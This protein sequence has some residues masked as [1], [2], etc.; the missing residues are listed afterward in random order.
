[1]SF[2]ERVTSVLADCGV[3]H[4]LLG[5]SAHEVDVVVPRSSLSALDA[6]LRLGRL[7]RVVQHSHHEAPWSRWYA[8]ETSEPGRYRWL[9]VACDPFGIGPYGLGPA[10]ALRHPGSAGRTCYRAAKL[11]V[12]GGE[13]AALRAEYDADPAAAAEALER[14]F[15]SAGRKLA[16]ALATDDGLPEALAQLGG[17]IQ[18]RRLTLERLVLRA[19]FGGI[20]AVRRLLRPS[21]LAIV[22]CGPDGVGKSTVTQGLLALR[23]SPFRRIVRLGQRRGPL[24]PPSRL[25]GRRPGDAT[26]PHARVP[27]GLLG[28][29]ARLAYMWLDAILG[30]VPRVALP[31]RRT[32]LVVLERGYDDTTVDPRRYRLSTPDWVAGA[33]AAL[34]PRPDLVVVLDAPADAICAR[35][36]ELARDEIDRQLEIWRGRGHV[37]VDASGS[38]EETLNA[39]LRAI[40]DRLAARHR[41]LHSADTAVRA[42]GTPAPGGVPYGVTSR[43][44]RTRF[45]VPPGRGPLHARVY[46]PG[47]TRDAI[48]ARALELRARTRLQRSLRLDPSGGIA[49][50]VADA[51]GVRN[52]QLAA[53][54]QRDDARGGR[55]LVVVRN[56]GRIVAYAKVA[57]SGDHLAREHALLTLLHGQTLRRVVTPRPLGLLDDRG[58]SVLLLEPLVARGNPLRRLGPAEVEAVAELAELGA[59]LEPVLGARDGLVPVHGDFAPWNCAVASDGR[60]ALWDWEEARLGLP[61]E[62]VFHWAT[63]RMLLLGRGHAEELIRAAL[64]TDSVLAGVAARLDVDVAGRLAALRAALERSSAGPEALRLLAERT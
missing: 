16:V 57:A 46:T 9:D 42:L 13:T 10:A 8:V 48:G 63:E 44:G 39:V 25:L 18:Q 60:L 27:S 36:A 56:G 38:A 24:G 58:L 53:A 55:A 12:K 6:A 7:G 3:E 2:A 40:D 14:T 1:M 32:T 54:A 30:W 19:V 50:L 49:P 31:R 20:R 59:A 17:A 37:T 45:L 5:E 43:R 28:S 34:L 21:G 47:R 64:A 4:A 11:A 22:L 33:F 52:V 35:K 41:S 62:D 61:L 23:P 15:G 51:L 26:S 29:T